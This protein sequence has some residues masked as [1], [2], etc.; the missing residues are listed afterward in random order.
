METATKGNDWFRELTWGNL[1][2]WAGKIAVTEGRMFQKNGAVKQLTK[3]G[4]NGLLSWVYDEEDFAVNVEVD[5][6]ELYGRCGCQGGNVC[7]HMVAV[8]IEY[9]ACLKQGK[10]LPVAAANDPRFYLL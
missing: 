4:N 8:V 2:L 7:P 1:V 9:I 3:T 10:Q 5:D 6:G